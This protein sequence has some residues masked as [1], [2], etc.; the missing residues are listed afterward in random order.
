[1]TNRKVDKSKKKGE[2][3]DDS[4]QRINLSHAA[5][6]VVVAKRPSITLVVEGD[7]EFVQIR[8]PLDKMLRLIANSGTGKRVC[9]QVLRSKLDTAIGDDDEDEEG[10]DYPDFR[11]P[12]LPSEDDIDHEDNYCTMCGQGM[13]ACNPRQL[14]RKVYCE[15]DLATTVAQERYDNERKKAKR[16]WL[17][18]RKKSN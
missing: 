14:C 9:L 18:E 15:N 11:P 3:E 12:F 17:R 5:A 8:I 13:G 6:G 1:M 16:K 4:T 2:R 7:E 10:F